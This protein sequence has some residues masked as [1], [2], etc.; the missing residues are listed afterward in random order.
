SASS[1]TIYCILKILEILKGKF[2]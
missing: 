2:F 1:L